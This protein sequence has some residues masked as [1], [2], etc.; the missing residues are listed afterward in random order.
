MKPPLTPAQQRLYDWLVLHFERSPC[1]PS[2]REM[3]R[4]LDLKSGAPIQN[5]LAGLQEK[6]L[7]TWQPGK[8]RTLQLVRQEAGVPILGTIA[9]GG[10]VE[11]FLPADIEHIPI[12]LFRVLGWSDRQV[13]NHFAVRVRGD[14]MIGALIDNGD[15]VILR[16]PS[17]PATVKDGTII[18][19]RVG[20]QMTLKYL[21]RLSAGKVQ[22]QP[23]NPNHLPIDVD[24]AELEIQGVF[25]GVMRNLV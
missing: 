20:S 17:D 25:A 19:A 9:A 12:E 1:S 2:I 16:R 6:G 5:T 10:L 3:M 23:A 24:A 11:T 13:E 15:V 21:H 14:S 7:V 22:L 4:G 18:A 8:A